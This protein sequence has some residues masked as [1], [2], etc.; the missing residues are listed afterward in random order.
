MVGGNRVPG[1]LGAGGCK[2]QD[3]TTESQRAAGGCLTLWAAG[4]RRRGG[5]EAWLL[6]GVE[7]GACW[8]QEKAVG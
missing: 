4:S 3:R 1:Q 5:G 2:G 8:W 7:S 6:A